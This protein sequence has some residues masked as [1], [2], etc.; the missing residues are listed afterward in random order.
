[1]RIPFPER[2]PLNRVAIF[3]VVLFMIQSMEHTALYFSAG[4]AAFIMIAAFAFNMAGGLTRASGA[5]VFFYSTLV[6]ILGVCYKAYLG[7]PAQS[8][9]LDPHTTIEAYV[10]SI[11]AM[12]AAVIV[13]R[14]FS[15]K[16]GLL[17]NV[18]KESEMYR[19]AI[20]CIVFGAAA[21]FLIS[22]LGESGA[23]LATGFAQLN[24]L[25]PLGIIIGV[26]YQIRRS[27]GSRSINVP[28]LLAAVY[29]FVYYGIINFSKQGM[30]TPMVCWLI[31]VCA[32]R[33]RLSAL[34]V[35]SC[36]LTAFI[37]FHYLVPYSQYGRRFNG[38]N[39][40]LS[41]KIATTTQLLE[42]P[43]ETRQKFEEV[44]DYTTYY[45]KPQGFWDRLQFVSVDDGLINLTDQGRVFGLLPLALAAENAVPHV[46]WPN[47]PKTNFG[48]VYMHEITGIAEDEETGVGIAFSPTSEAYHMATWTGV[49]VVA[50]LVW[51]LLFVV[52]DSLFGDLRATPWGLLALT[53]ISHAAPEGALTGVIY[54]V[55][56]GT[57][58]LLFCALFATW[59]APAFAD[60][61]LGPRPAVPAPLPAQIPQT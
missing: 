21:P 61:V 47:K 4:C 26:M 22:L 53:M 39:I 45:N 11:A 50:P 32:L 13:S 18:L 5:Y 36:L 8:N 10:G 55:T 6:V 34:Q 57:E 27:G 2:I 59:V 20:G 43:E 49:L 38:P 58:A 40:S 41:Q 29:F 28:I 56:F 33:Y 17:Q 14:R 35:F 51:F 16:S 15:R 19:S 24:Q 9:L 52:F 25:I 48:N 42:H 44:T 3:A 54:L 37:V 30:L 7:E 31:P 46:L 1:V 23:K 60:V 12:L